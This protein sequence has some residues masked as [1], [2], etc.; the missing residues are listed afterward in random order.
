MPV[1][2]LSSLPLTTRSSLSPAHNFFTLSKKLRSLSSLSL[3]STFRSQSQAPQQIE[4]GGEE[5]EDVLGDCLVFEDGIFEDPYLEEENVSSSTSFYRTK[6]QKPKGWKKSIAP[7]VEPQNLVPEDWQQIVAEL[8][9]S[10]KDRRKIAQGLEYGQRL[11]K[12]S[13]VR[14]VNLEEYLKYRNEK[15]AQLKQVILDNPSGYSLRNDENR[16]NDNDRD[17]LKGVL[18]ANSSGI[19]RVEPRDPRRAVYG[20]KLDDITEFFN[21]GNYQPGDT[22]S[23][24]R[25]KLFSKEEKLLL[26]ARVP[27]LAVAT[28][29]KWL[30]LHT[31]A[32]SGNFYLSSTLLKHILDINAAD[33]DGLTALHKAIICKKQA[34][35][36]FLLRESANPFVRDKDGATLM[37]YAV[38]TASSQAIKILLLYNVDINLQDNDGWTPLHVA[39]QARRT[40][41]LRLLLIKGADRTLR[42]KDGLTPLELC[43]YSGRDLRTYELIKLLKQLP[44]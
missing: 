23:E 19:T 7:E 3:Y 9:I 4:A 38:Q 10:K 15:L 14:S 2:S 21:N 13:K 11:E 22:K 20:K 32:A 33:K 16:R 44:K 40:D 35:T 42:N 43:L 18:D 12:K 27:K 17:D 24:G 1:S 8:N 36:N 28:S 26:N 34:I 29:A 41:V 30:P 37:H 31:L 25:P 39:V 6:T 5:E